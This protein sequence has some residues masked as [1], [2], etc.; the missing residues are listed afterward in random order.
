MAATKP[1]AVSIIASQILIPKFVPA[2]RAVGKEDPQINAAFNGWI[3]QLRSDSTYDDFAET[4]K[5]IVNDVQKSNP[6]FQYSISGATLQKMVEPQLNPQPPLRPGFW[7]MARVTDKKFGGATETTMYVPTSMKIDR[8]TVERPCGFQERE[9][10]GP[11]Y[12]QTQCD[13]TEVAGV[14]NCKLVPVGSKVRQIIPAQCTENR[15]S[16][17]KGV[18]IKTTTDDDKKMMQT[19]ARPV[20]ERISEVVS[21]RPNGKPIEYEKL[22]RTG[23]APAGPYE[24]RLSI[25]QM[26]ALPGGPRRDIGGGSAIPLKKAGAV[27]GGAIDMPE[28]ATPMKLNETDLDNQVLPVPDGMMERPS[29]WSD[30]NP[31]GP[32]NWNMYDDSY[33]TTSAKTRQFGFPFRRHHLTYDRLKFFKHP[34]DYLEWL[35]SVSYKFRAEYPQFYTYNYDPAIDTEATLES[36]ILNGLGNLEANRK[37]FDRKDLLG[38]SSAADKK[39]MHPILRKYVETPPT[40]IWFSPLTH[41]YLRMDADAN[42]YPEEATTLTNL[43]TLYGAIVDSLNA[44]YTSKSNANVRLRLPVPLKGNTPVMDTMAFAE[45]YLMG[46]LERLQYAGYAYNMG[47]GAVVSATVNSLLSPN[48]RKYLRDESIKYLELFRLEDGTQTFVYLPGL[49]RMMAE[50]HGVKLPE[51]E[52]FKIDP[53]WKT[54]KARDVPVV[55]DGVVIPSEVIAANEPSYYERMSKKSGS[56]RKSGR[57]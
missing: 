50:S 37:Y 36:Q 3:M 4:L 10:E 39:E 14:Q 9:V 24:P 46:L 19:T 34:T 25:Q 51:A 7:D 16:V 26:A 33:G 48:E 23:E 54:M 38:G 6:G 1:G 5:S 11:I 55:V 15:F 57:R 53:S 49:R 56:R 52:G 40:D 28:T 31:E 12:M 42:K 13:R 47:S 2:L 17:L 21:V 20:V 45:D 29:A 35:I 43:N 18:E 41:R 30:L 8:R 22:L 44:G 27:S 32:L